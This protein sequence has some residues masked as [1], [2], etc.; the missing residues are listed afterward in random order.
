MN[1]NNKINIFSCDLLSKYFNIS[2]DELNTEV[3]ILNAL[4][5]TKI[6]KFIFSAKLASIWCEHTFSKLAVVKTKLKN[7]RYWP[8]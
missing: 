4:E 6:N 1:L 8:G 7:T 5:D 3:N 2:T